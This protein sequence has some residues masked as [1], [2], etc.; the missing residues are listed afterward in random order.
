VLWG[1]LKAYGAGP[2]WMNSEGSVVALKP[3]GDGQHQVK[4]QQ[5]RDQAP[6]PSL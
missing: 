4:G 1:F 2:L 5:G 6:C 3:V